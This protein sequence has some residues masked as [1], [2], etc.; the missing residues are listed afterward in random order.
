M[1]DKS[2][3]P[4]LNLRAF[5]VKAFNAKSAKE[6]LS[7]Q[8]ILKVN[9]KN[10]KKHI[11]IIIELGKVRITFFVAISTSVGYLLH[12]KIFDL[13][14]ALV[15][16]G[17]F[18]LACG[19]SAINH[20]QERITDALMDRTKGRPIPSGRISKEY[21][22]IISLVLIVLGLGIIYFSSN[23]TALILGVIAL[24]WYNVIY[25]PM[26]KKYALAVVPGS[27]IGAIPP[28]IG[29][30][31]SGGYL[32]DMEIIALA[33]FFFIW[34]IPHFW[35]LLLIHGKDY[36]KA[37]LP[38]LTKIFSAL[39]LGR[40]TFVWIAALATSC[41]LIPFFNVPS[42]V[43]SI[44]AM[45]LLGVLLLWKTRGILS[46]CLDCLEKKFFRIAFLHV[47]LYVLAIIIIISIDKLLLKK[48]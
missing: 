24:I 25:T 10:L 39:Q 26:K 20:Y 31:A 15:V 21:A 13:T 34:Q 37:G 27:V 43:Y 30:A 2:S 29:W 3:R 41:M 16:L 36:E 18:L 32:F 35:L 45:L 8:R 12:S 23:V 7:A 19:S 6:A 46:D 22:L 47:N 17:V 14:M 1:I 44:A 38:T 48:F 28:M 40:I 33:F 9:L 4:S 11:A 5:A 42:S